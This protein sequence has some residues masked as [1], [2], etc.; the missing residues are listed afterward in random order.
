MNHTIE[1]E[2]EGRWAV[3]RYHGE[4]AIGH[5]LDLLENLVS[6]PQWTPACDRIVVYDKGRLG[7]VSPE[8]FRQIRQQLK[9]FI[10]AL[11]GDAPNF[12]AQVCSDP[13][14]RPLVEY[15]VNYARTAYQPPVELFADIAAAEAWLKRQ[16]AALT[17]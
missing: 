12:S 7:G 4:V 6:L 5:A 13:M 15:W 3:I 9:D 10:I 17:G 2:P 14:Q 16:R 11:Y 1:I 8:D